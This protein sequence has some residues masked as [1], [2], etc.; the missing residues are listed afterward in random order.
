[1]KTNELKDILG[2][3]ELDSLNATVDFVDLYEAASRR[4][5]FTFT[6]EFSSG[7]TS[8]IEELLGEAIGKV[9]VLE[10]TRLPILFV[11]GTQKRAYGFRHS[12]PVKK[13]IFSDLEDASSRINSPYDWLLVSLPNETLKT[14]NISDTPGT[15]G[16]SAHQV[17][18]I[19]NIQYVWCS[20]YG[21]VM[22]ET[23][24]E[25]L[26]NLGNQ[27]IYFVAT[28]ADLVDLD[29]QEEIE[30][31]HEEILEVN[32][33]KNQIIYSVL[34][35]EIIEHQRELELYLNDWIS[36]SE[37]SCSQTIVLEQIADTFN[38]EVVD[39][40]S[41]LLK[42]DEELL[43]SFIIS[44]KKQYKDESELLDRHKSFKFNLLDR[45]RSFQASNDDYHTSKMIRNVEKH[46][47][48]YKKQQ[49][50]P[51]ILNENQKQTLESSEK[52]MMLLKSDIM[53]LMS[54]GMKNQKSWMYDQNRTEKMKEYKIKI[55]DKHSFIKK[56]RA[57]SLHSENQLQLM[58]LE[59]K[60]IKRFLDVF[61]DKQWYATLKNAGEFKYSIN[62]QEQYQFS[63]E[64]NVQDVKEL[65]SYITNIV[66]LEQYS[67]DIKRSRMIK[68]LGNGIYNSEKSNVRRFGFKTF[69]GEEDASPW[70]ANRMVLQQLKDE[71]QNH[72]DL[73]SKWFSN[74]EEHKKIVHQSYEVIKNNIF[75]LQ[76]LLNE[77]IQSDIYTDTLNELLDELN[78]VSN[79]IKLIL[80]K[81]VYTYDISSE[82]MQG[83]PHFTRIDYFIHQIMYPAFFIHSICLFSLFYVIFA[84]DLISA[85][86]YINF[87]SYVKESWFWIPLLG[88]SLMITYVQH[89]L[90]DR[91]HTAIPVT[92]NTLCGIATLFV[93][94][95]W[96][97]E[98][99]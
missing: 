30:E 43:N 68:T 14:F 22:T 52:G 16:S 86:L 70:R 58:N 65:N 87:P 47:I 13:V 28:K 56:L 74:Q 55:N 93:I 50:E 53:K 63:P 54:N 24:Q 39:R 85:N 36:N 92:A 23:K 72:L 76:Q 35:T 98:N 81:E 41:T 57:H 69:V 82:E 9:D 59:E 60:E 79:H 29:E 78:V 25:T 26:K 6:G 44:S 73:E 17:S 67:L 10:A 61:L 45:W 95:I 33:F 90:E 15:N 31:V 51:W 71:K 84:T 8:L 96:L 32:S 46:F 20:P 38:G 89:R 49:Y 37:A 83:S 5:S 11:Y 12:K 4:P 91:K 34:E 62:F 2:R 48:F 88:A 42:K 80:K 75:I 97:S 64:L 21:E 19:P 66:E 18:F 94:I 27:D 1:M 77:H 99:Q 3:L 7:K 40:I